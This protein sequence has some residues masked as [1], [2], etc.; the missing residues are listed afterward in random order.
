VCPYSLIKTV[1]SRDICLSS[2]A[3]MRN[4]FPSWWPLRYSFRFV[5]TAH[6]SGC[7]AS[8][9]E[10]TH[11]VVLGYAFR[12]CEPESLAVLDMK[13]TVFLEATLRNSVDRFQRFGEIISS[14]FSAEA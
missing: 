3:M 14:I 1:Q 10:R 9:D 7:V 11:V 6:G 5:K 12:L 13:I 2:H 4:P 8:G